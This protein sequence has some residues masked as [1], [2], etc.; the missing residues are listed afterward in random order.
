ML[1]TF[2]VSGHRPIKPGLSRSNR[3]V[4]SP[5]PEALVDR[6]ELLLASKVAGNSGVR[7]ELISVC[8]ELLGQNAMT[9][10]DYKKYCCIHNNVDN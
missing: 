7:N 2:T 10:P 9:K 4:W 8:D 5:C 3:D 1:A 6:R